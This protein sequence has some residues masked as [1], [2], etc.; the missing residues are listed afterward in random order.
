MKSKSNSSTGNILNNI[1][2]AS[3]GFFLGLVSYFLI[4]ILSIILIVAIIVA[5]VIWWD[6]N[7]RNKY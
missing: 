2:L 1:R 4:K 3:I 7:K 5:M 6:K